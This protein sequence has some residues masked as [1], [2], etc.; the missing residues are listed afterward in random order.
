M[1]Y[2]APVKEMLFVMQDIA[3]IDKVASIPG[4]EDYGYTRL[5]LC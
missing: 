3:D 4:F 2:T 1:S 5:R